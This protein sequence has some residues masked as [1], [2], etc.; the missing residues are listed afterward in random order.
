MKKNHRGYSCFKSEES[1]CLY[2]S[3]IRNLTYCT[4]RNT[5]LVKLRNHRFKTK[6]SFHFDNQKLEVNSIL[7]NLL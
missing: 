4:F 7:F 5:F 1:L 6:I 3:K 2:G